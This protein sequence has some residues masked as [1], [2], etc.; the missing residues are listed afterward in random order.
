MRSLKIKIFCQG[1]NVLWKQWA[2]LYKSGEMSFEA[3][4]SKQV[5]P[6]Q[7]THRGSW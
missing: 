5:S 3:Q 2:F 6:L 4:A 1:M 7:K